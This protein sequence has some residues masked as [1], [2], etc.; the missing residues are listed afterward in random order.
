MKNKMKKETIKIEVELPDSIGDRSIAN[1]IR[2]L[3]VN[4]GRKCVIESI[5]PAGSDT[6]LL[7]CHVGLDSFESFQNIYNNFWITYFFS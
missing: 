3:S 2:Q 4:M 6:I 5:T 1:F 7:T